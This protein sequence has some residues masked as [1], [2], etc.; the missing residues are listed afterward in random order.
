M[1]LMTDVRSNFLSMSMMSPN[2]NC[3]LYAVK[4]VPRLLVRLSSFGVSPPAVSH[5]TCGTP[6]L[7]CLCSTRAV[8]MRHS[9]SASRGMCRRLLHLIDV[10]SSLA[11]ATSNVWLG[12]EAE[13]AARTLVLRRRAIILW[14]LSMSS[15]E[16]ARLFI[17]FWSSAAI[18]IASSCS[19]P[20]AGA[21][22]SVQ[23]C[24]QSILSCASERSLMLSCPPSCT[25]LSSTAPMKCSKSSRDMRLSMSLNTCDIM[26]MMATFWIRI[27]GDWRRQ[28]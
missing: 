3:T 1:K 23:S 6:S 15:L 9:M 4:R 10:R 24:S 19:A 27:C 16:G 11:A 8:C 12:K 25:L 26:W 18:F 13:E 5:E 21:G 20:G 14:N 2:Q 22:L 7:R 17:F 28:T